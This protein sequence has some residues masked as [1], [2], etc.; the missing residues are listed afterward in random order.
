MSRKQIRYGY[1]LLFVEKH[2]RLLQELLEIEARKHVKIYGILFQM[3]IVKDTAFR[4][5]GKHIRQ[6]FLKVN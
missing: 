6:S 2:T 3:N 4:I 1:G 5:F